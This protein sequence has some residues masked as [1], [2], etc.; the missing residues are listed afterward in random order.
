MNKVVQS[1]AFEIRKG[2]D[3]VDSNFRNLSKKYDE[4][5][6]V[7]RGYANKSNANLFNEL[8]NI[9]EGYNENQ[10]KPILKLNQLTLEAAIENHKK[11]NDVVNSL[12]V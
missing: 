4:A 5:A 1:N 3:E 10:V 7:M 12:D 6:T 9:I 11:M 2:L 8:A